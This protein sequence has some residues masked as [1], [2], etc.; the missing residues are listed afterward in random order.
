MKP[1]HLI[2]IDSRLVPEDIAAQYRDLIEK[3]CCLLDMC[4]Y[5][6]IFWEIGS[7]EQDS[8]LYGIWICGDTYADAKV[9]DFFGQ[10]F[11]FL[12]LTEVF[13]YERE[14]I[15]SSIKSMNPAK[16]IFVEEFKKM[17]LLDGTLHFS[18]VRSSFVSRDSLEDIVVQL[19]TP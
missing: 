16:C 4:G 10:Y 18:N 9:E 17:P 7:I 15:I 14:D 1:V 2:T 6:I 13:L 5:P 3:T 19:E 11:L 8:D 12:P